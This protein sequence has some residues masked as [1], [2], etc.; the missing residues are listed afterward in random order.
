MSAPLHVHA[1]CCMVSGFGFREYTCPFLPLTMS[2]RQ[3]TARFPRRPWSGGEVTTPYTCFF[4]G[5]SASG[6]HS[7]TVVHTCLYACTCKRSDLCLLTFKS[8]AAWV[9]LTARLRARQNLRL[10]SDYLICRPGAGGYLVHAAYAAVFCP[11][12]EQMYSCFYHGLIPPVVGG[13]HSGGV[14]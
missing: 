9:G 7:G 10:F 6:G 13:L 2:E 5:A 8:P 1:F 11:C 3:S 4:A 14:L 12:L